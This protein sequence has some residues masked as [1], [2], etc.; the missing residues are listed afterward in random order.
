MAQGVAS[1][2]QMTLHEGKE[3]DRRRAG[4]ATAGHFFF[5][6]NRE[7]PESAASR[8]Q[9]YVMRPDGG[10]AQRITDTREGVRDYRLEP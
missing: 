9:I 10:E 2:R 5:L 1:T 7:A 8:N 6:S 3:R 4:R